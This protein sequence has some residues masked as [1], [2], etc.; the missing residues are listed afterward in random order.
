VRRAGYAILLITAVVHAEPASKDDFH[1]HMKAGYD[2]EA[3]NKW[4]EAAAEFEVAVAFKDDAR[5]YAELGWSAMLA[6][7]LAKARKADVSAVG[8]ATSDKLKA[9]ALFN[10]GTVEEKSGDRLA[11]RL[12]YEA[13]LAVAPNPAVKVA[14][15]KLGSVSGTMPNACYDVRDQIVPATHGAFV[16]DDGAIRTLGP[17]LRYCDTPAR[18][19]IA[20][21]TGEK[22]VD[23]R[24]TALAGSAIAITRKTRAVA[25]GAL[26]SGSFC[27]DNCSPMGHA[28]CSEIS[29]CMLR[30]SIAGAR[31][32][33]LYPSDRSIGDKDDAASRAACTPWMQ[34]GSL[35]CSTAHHLAIVDDRRC[36]DDK[37]GIHVTV[38][39]AR[40]GNQTFEA[41]GDRDLSAATPTY[42]FGSVTLAIAPGATPTAKLTVDKTTE[43][44]LALVIR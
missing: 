39:D 14:L 24:T 8:H 36:G 22:Q 2:L 12:S 37:V 5:A 35:I 17:N 9:T 19:V 15:D 6:G 29:G 11:A 28:G 1:A 43:D 7:D 3:Q 42:R 18:V 33:A 44:C 23:V 10:L 41:D 27:I 32:F 26:V 38:H 21:I 25:T 30:T 40:S 31:R 4:T 13:S 20:E 34:H 16:R